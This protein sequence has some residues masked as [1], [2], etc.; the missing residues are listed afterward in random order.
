MSNGERLFH[1]G[2]VRVAT[3]NNSV[4]ALYQAAAAVVWFKTGWDIAT[5]LTGATFPTGC[6]QR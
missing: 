2:L 6:W 5:R 3:L 1:N 4:C